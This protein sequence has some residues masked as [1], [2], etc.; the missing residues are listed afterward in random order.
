MRSILSDRSAPPNPISTPK[1]RLRELAAKDFFEGDTDFFDFVRKVFRH[2]VE[3]NA[4]QDKTVKVTVNGYSNQ[5][6]YLSVTENDR[7][8][9]ADFLGSRG[10]AF[11]HLYGNFSG[12]SRTLASIGDMK[13]DDSYRGAVF[14]ATV[15]AV[16][17]HLGIVDKTVHCTGDGLT[18]CANELVSLIKKEYGKPRVALI[19]V[20]SAMLEALAREF[21]LRVTD[22]DRK[23]AGT[24]LGGIPVLSSRHTAASIAWSDLVLVTG[25]ALNNE[26]LQAL[27]AQNPTVVYAQTGSGRMLPKISLNA[28]LKKPTI[29]CGVTS[30][31][32][33][34]FLRLPRFCPYAS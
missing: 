28:C 13:T 20:H 18:K 19:G 11:A 5:G 9:E 21:E 4:W 17:R 30:A 1:N 16:A 12:T 7:L 25:S 6:N 10:Q 15:N 33:A 23:N 34:Q 3:E 8:I 24:T 2:L 26:T 29:S 27:V 32:V 31:A 22:T 14:L